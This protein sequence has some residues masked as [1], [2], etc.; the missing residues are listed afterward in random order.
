LSRWL[1]LAALTVLVSA[2]PRKAD[3][4]RFE[5]APN[6]SGWVVVREGVRGA[7]E[8]PRDGKTWV[9]KIPTSGVLETSSLPRDGVGSVDFVVIDGD[10][11]SRL[12]RQ[13]SYTKDKTWDHVVACCFEG[14]QDGDVRVRRFY[15]GQGPPG[16]SPKS[17]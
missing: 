1:I 8:L 10:K 9:L 17:N 4:L 16:E 11:K 3:P 5:L 2:C 13:V 12:D 6:F 15:V 7:P 14:A